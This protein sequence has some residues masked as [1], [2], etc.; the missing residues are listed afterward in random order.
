[1]D[2]DCWFPLLHQK[3]SL[4]LVCLKEMH[5]VFVD[6]AGVLDLVLGAWVVVWVVAGDLDLVVQA[7]LAGFLGWVDLA[8]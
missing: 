2:L 3:L 7:D 5:A 1:M 6:V 8:Q 4:L